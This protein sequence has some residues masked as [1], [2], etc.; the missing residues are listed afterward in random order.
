MIKSTY[1]C[2]SEDLCDL[3]VQSCKVVF[4]PY[5]TP[6]CCQQIRGLCTTFYCWLLTV[7]GILNTV[8]ISDSF[9]KAASIPESTKSGDC[10]RCLFLLLEVDNGKYSEMKWCYFCFLFLL[11]LLIHSQTS[12]CV[13]DLLV[14]RSE[15][16]ESCSAIR[17]CHSLPS[18]GKPSQVWQSILK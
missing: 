6:L 14:W 4:L 3:H 12:F 2:K 11:C 10:C 15:K 7:G 18:L 9:R 1:A 13:S 8:K 17:H 5:W 16:C